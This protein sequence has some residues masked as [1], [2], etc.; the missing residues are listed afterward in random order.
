MKQ[1]RSK[2]LAGNLLKTD[3]WL[4]SVGCQSFQDNQLFIPHADRLALEY[5]ASCS[6]PATRGPL[7][8]IWDQIGGSQDFDE[9][10]DKELDSSYTGNVIMEDE[11]QE[12]TRSYRCRDEVV[13]FLTKF[14]PIV[15]LQ[16][17]DSTE[18]ETV[19]DEIE[20]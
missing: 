15:V 16:D 10:R 20:G 7:N 5:H 9:Q 18:S 17:L 14:L 6:V 8:G 19:S 12:V 13:R 11:L 1:H 4:T 2:L 3:F